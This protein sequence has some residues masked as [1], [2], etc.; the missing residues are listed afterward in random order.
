MLRFEVECLG[1]NN[2]IVIHELID[3]LHP[4]FIDAYHTKSDSDIVKRFHSL[5]EWKKEFLSLKQQSQSS[6]YVINFVH[7]ESLKELFVNYIIYSAPYTII[8]FYMPSVPTYFQEH[9]KSIKGRIRKIKSFIQTATYNTYKRAFTIRLSLLLDRI[10]L[11]RADDFILSTDTRLTSNEVT[12]VLKASYFDYVL[13]LKHRK[14]QK[15]YVK[16]DF[17]VFLD[18]GIPLFKTDAL[19][20]GIKV[21]LTSDIWY[22]ALRD[23]FRHIEELMGCE[24]VIASHPKHSYNN[25]SLD[26]FGGRKIFSGKTVELVKDS[27]FVVTIGSAAVAYAVLFHKPIVLVYSYEMLRNRNDKILDS[28]YN[29]E[30]LGCK[31]VNIDASPLP[32]DHSYYSSVNINKYK[33]YTQEYL[34]SRDD[35]LSNCEVITREIIEKKWEYSKPQ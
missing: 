1:K 15:R 22:P 6:V 31:Q 25:G 34:S 9:S 30:K 2:D 32:S 33:K 13:F 17:I 28:N 11:R 19:L 21:G 3:V 12:K 5:A 10:L 23:F 20:S 14:S 24:V 18:I 27:K 29:A 35:E 4:K 7:S 8:R 26:V 16:N